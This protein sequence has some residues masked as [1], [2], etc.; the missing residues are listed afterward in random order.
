MSISMK[1]FGTILKRFNWPECTLKGTAP[2]LCTKNSEIE[3]AA[4]D[5]QRCY[6]VLRPPTPR[7]P[8]SQSATSIP[9]PLRRKANMV[10]S[11]CA[12][13][14]RVAQSSPRSR[15]LLPTVTGVRRHLTRSTDSRLG[16][17]RLRSLAPYRSLR[18]LPR[19]GLP[20]L[21]HCGQYSQRW[22]R[23]C[24]LSSLT[25]RG[26]TRPQLGHS[27]TPR[28]LP[29]GCSTHSPSSSRSRRGT[30]SV[31]ALPMVMACFG[32]SL[33]RGG[34]RLH[35]HIIDLALS[36]GVQHGFN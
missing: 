16:R 11:I 6:M 8:D 4:S 19:L 14:G 1:R 17:P 3:N 31:A 36:A 9:K 25:A 27:L 28:S 13:S 22:S 10:P 15:V 35:P 2:L 29:A 18:S 7:L 33:C 24:V 20:M 34:R 12:H 32:S 23:C 5:Y 30:P 21:T 26:H